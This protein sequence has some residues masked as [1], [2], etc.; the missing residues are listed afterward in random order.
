MGVLQ[1]TFNLWYF[2]TSLS[3]L[4]LISMLY[5]CIEGFT[6]SNNTFNW[7]VNINKEMFMLLLNH[8]LN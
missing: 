1:A 3:W 6:Y 7:F 5:V 2:S 4:F 8:G